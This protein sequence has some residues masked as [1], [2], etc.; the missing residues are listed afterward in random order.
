MLLDTAKFYFPTENEKRVKY[1]NLT[2][3]FESNS[4]GFS[5]IYE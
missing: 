5:F 4:F 2:N 1:V 3:N